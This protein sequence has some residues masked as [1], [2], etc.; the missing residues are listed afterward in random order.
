MM[1]IESAKIFLTTIQS[2]VTNPLS[3]I[4]K[5]KREWNSK[6]KVNARLFIKK[7]PRNIS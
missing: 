1:T 3:I 4:G 5:F 2:T 6:S 7:K